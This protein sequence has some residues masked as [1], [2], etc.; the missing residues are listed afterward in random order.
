MIFQVLPGS[1]V[2]MGYE[3]GPAVRG[4]MIAQGMTLS[5]MDHVALG[6]TFEGSSWAFTEQPLFFLARE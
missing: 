4:V 6:E 5:V 1:H 2:G 3:S